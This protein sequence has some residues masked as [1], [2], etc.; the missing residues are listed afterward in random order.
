M[1]RVKA[2]PQNKR[3]YYQIDNLTKGHKKAIRNA[4]FDIGRKNQSDIRK[5][6]L[7]GPKTGRLYRV[8]GRVHRASA[9]G[10]SPANVTGRLAKSASYNV[11]GHR[12]VEFGYAASAHYGGY[13]E[14]GTVKM[15]RRPNVAKVA[16]DNAQTFINYMVR[17]YR[18]NK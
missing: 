1:I 10:E 13:L 7:T 5:N 2:D 14:D 4:S 3:V 11:K 6:I 12:A 9:E 8:S 15:K 18:E 17:A 16:D